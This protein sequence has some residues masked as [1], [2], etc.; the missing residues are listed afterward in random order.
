MTGPTRVPRQVTR[1]W[2]GK[3][4]GRR[5]GDVRPGIKRNTAESGLAPPENPAA[6]LEQVPQQRAR[7]PCRGGKSPPATASGREN[8]GGPVSVGHPTFSAAGRGRNPLAGPPVRA[9]RSV[10]DG[11]PVPGKRSAPNAIE[12]RARRSFGT[13]VSSSARIL[14]PARCNRHRQDGPRRNTGPRPWESS[15]SPWGRE[16]RRRSA[17]EPSSSSSSH[18]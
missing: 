5:P 12:V 1:G 8:L 4:P 11:P 18:R 16:F 14:G 13:L 6:P 2:P 7:F 17:P 15:P 9:F 10:L 3:V